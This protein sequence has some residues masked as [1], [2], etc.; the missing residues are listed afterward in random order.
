MTY[1]I[2]RDRLEVEKLA[3]DIYLSGDK[4]IKYI[5]YADLRILKRNSTLKYA[6]I[7]K[8]CCLETEFIQEISEAIKSIDIPVSELN[9]YL[10]NIRINDA[11]TSLKWDD[12]AKFVQYVDG[13]KAGVCPDD[14]FDGLYAINANSEIP[15]GECY[16]YIIFGTAKTEEDK[17]ED[18]KYEQMIEDYRNSKIPPI[19][20]WDTYKL[21]NQEIPLHKKAT[22]R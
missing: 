13:I 21:E 14:Y 5:D 2:I 15:K 12:V 9:Y 1:E 10:I 18:A 6:I 22:G 7:C 8:I 20:D 3:E 19:N 11:D 4:A 16:I 17:L